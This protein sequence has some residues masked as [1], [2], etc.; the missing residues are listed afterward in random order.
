MKLLWLAW[1]LVCLVVPLGA[2]VRLSQAGLGCPD[3]PGCYGQITPHHAS[4][5]IAHAQQLEPDGP[6]SSGKA[7]REMAHRYLASTLGLVIVLQLVSSLRQQRLRGF[8]SVLLLAVLLQGLLGMLTVTLQLKPLVVSAHLGL[9]M[10]LAA[11]LA[12]RVWGERLSPIAVP[13]LLRGLCWVLSALL[14]GQIL[15]GGWV[16]A[17]HAALACQGFPSCNGSFWPA[18][19]FSG[20]YPLLSG[21][22]AADDLTLITLHWLHRLGASAVLLTVLLLLL[23]GWRV[24]GLRP[25]LLWL[26]A[27]TGLQL[28]LGVANVLLQLPLPLA[29]LH[30][31]GAMLLLSVTLLLLRRL[32]RTIR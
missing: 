21:Q 31:I 14:L 20:I 22:M 24:P 6:V 9:G 11:A 13:R 8:S 28:L 12:V 7:W 23:R 3:W 17:S 26:G 29:V 10:L 25:A 4:A 18:L 19:R 1:L 5:Q 27:V 32:R 30:N 16:S 15:L 2:Y